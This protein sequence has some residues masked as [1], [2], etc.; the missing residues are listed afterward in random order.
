MDQYFLIF[1]KELFHGKLVFMFMN[2]NKITTFLLNVLFHKMIAI[3]LILIL[4]NVT[5]QIVH[6]QCN[7]CSGGGNVCFVG[8]LYLVDSDCYCCSNGAQ[9]PTRSPSYT[10]PPVSS[11][12]VFKTTSASGG[13]FAGTETVQLASGESKP[14]Q[15]VVIG[16]E[17]LVYALNGKSVSYSPV[18]AIPHGRNSETANFVTV[19]TESG[20]QLKLTSDHILFGGKCGLSHNLIRADEIKINDCVKTVDGEEAIATVT[21]APGQGIYTVVTKLDGLLVVNG[22]VA[23]PFAS[24]HLVANTFYNIYRALHKVCP[25]LM[26]TNFVTVVTKAFG[27]IVLSY[28]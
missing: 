28:F 1:S 10:K 26:Q 21:A 14:M 25:S 6:S 17:I 12:P 24:N 19:I 4:L 13:C 9:P 8:T 2:L 15:A 22:I 18:I 5:F 27:E 16:D 20:L 11:P 23:S 3:V 7:V